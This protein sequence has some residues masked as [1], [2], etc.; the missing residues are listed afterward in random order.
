ML[1]KKEVNMKEFKNILVISRSS[2]D[3]PKVLETGIK[4]RGWK[5]ALK[6]YINDYYL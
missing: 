1:L 3:C 4:L 2:K 5:E 6:E